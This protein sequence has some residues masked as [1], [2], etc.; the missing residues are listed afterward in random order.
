MIISLGKEIFF[1]LVKVFFEGDFF[2]SLFLF[3]SAYKFDFKIVT[4]LVLSLKCLFFI[5]MKLVF[6]MGLF[7]HTA[8]VSK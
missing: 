3:Q 5:L 2:C 7:R 8:I 4:V 6:K 1:N